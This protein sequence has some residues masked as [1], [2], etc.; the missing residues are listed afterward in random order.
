MYNLL[1]PQ[2]FLE[3]KTPK[4]LIS[5]HTHLRYIDIWAALPLS[6]ELYLPSQSI[7]VSCHLRPNHYI[8]NN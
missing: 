2:D 3:K 1:A 7:T 5:F 4:A 8:A 6:T